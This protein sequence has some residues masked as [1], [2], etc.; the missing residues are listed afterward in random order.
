MFG[1]LLGSKSSSATSL[2]FSSQSTFFL[3]TVSEQNIDV[4][5]SILQKSRQSYAL[6]AHQGMKPWQDPSLQKLCSSGTYAAPT[7]LILLFNSLSTISALLLS[8]IYPPLVT[9]FPLHAL[10]ESCHNCNITLAF[11]IAYHK[12]FK[13]YNQLTSPT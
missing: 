11:H 7:E 5:P 9:C 12:I 3:K 8:H 13:S 10:L 2:T 6:E 1:K 4:K